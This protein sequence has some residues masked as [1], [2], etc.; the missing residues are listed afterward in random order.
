MHHMITHG[1][2]PLALSGVQHDLDPDVLA[3]G[4]FEACYQGGY[5][6]G[7]LLFDVQQACDQGV[8]L[9]ACRPTGSVTWQLGAMAARADVLFDVGAAADAVHPANAVDWYFAGSPSW[10]FAP[11]GAGV[12]RAPCDTSVG[13]PD[14]RLCWQTGNNTLN[15]GGRCGAATGLGAGWERVVFERPGGL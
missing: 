11:A 15:R 10:G 8:L 12:Q 7:R 14:D 4:G 6:S 13:A 1:P 9:M 3:A 5:D 2:R